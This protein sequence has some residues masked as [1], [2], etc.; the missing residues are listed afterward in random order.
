MLEGKTVGKV[1][2]SCTHLAKQPVMGDRA[3]HHNKRFSNAPVQQ[4]CCHNESAIIKPVQAGQ[5]D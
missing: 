2:G 5:E 3:K 4:S 1:S